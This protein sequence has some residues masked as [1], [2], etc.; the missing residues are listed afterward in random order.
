MFIDI[1]I[2]GRTPLRPGPMPSTPFWAMVLSPQTGLPA[3]SA[4]DGDGVIFSSDNRPECFWTFALGYTIIPVP[5]KILDSCSVNCKVRSALGALRE[6]TE[7]CR[8]LFDDPTSVRL[9]RIWLG[10]KSGLCFTFLIVD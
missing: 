6:E 10:A 5:N 3:C 4:Y 8:G 9:P 1:I 2:I 7:N